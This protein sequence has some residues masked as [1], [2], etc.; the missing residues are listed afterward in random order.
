MGGV[1]DE[2]IAGRDQG[3]ICTGAVAAVAFAQLRGGG[4]GCGSPQILL[5]QAPLLTDYGIG[6]ATRMGLSVADL[7][8][9][10]AA[11]AE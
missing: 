7:P 10:T 8:A 9:V 4:L 6:V 3:R 5:L 11:A 1:E 2:R